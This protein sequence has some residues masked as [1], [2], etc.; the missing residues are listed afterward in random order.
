MRIRVALAA[1]IASLALVALSGCASLANDPEH[2]DSFAANYTIDA[3]GTAHV[4]ETIHYDFGSTPDRHGILRFLDSHFVQSATQDR[5]YKY[6]NLHVSSP[7]GASA[8][9]STAT[10]EDVLVQVGN[11]NATVSGKQTYI[12]SYDI[13]GALNQTTSTSGA[14]LDEL[15]W[16]ATG[17]DWQVPIDSA[18]VSV[19]GPAGSTAV[20]CF[21][22]AP[23]A[24]TS[25]QS[26]TKTA[27]G[28]T[29]TQGEFPAGD[30][31]TVDVGW[32]AG[33]FTSTAP[34]LEPHLSPDSANVYA[35]SNNGP[36]PFWTPWN[37]G[38]GLGLLVLIPLSYL[39]FVRLRDRDQEFTGE[40]PGTVPLDTPSAPVGPAPLH[41][42]LVVQYEPPKGF[43][44]G[45]VSLLM[46][47]QQSK[48]DVTVT[49]L[50]LAARGHLR[51][52]EVAGGS[53]SKASD[54][55][56]V[57]T[58]EKATVGDTAALLPHESLLL[59]DLFAGDTK[60][61]SLSNLKYT[62]FSEYTAVEVAIKAWVQGG[63]Y[64]IDKLTRTHPVLRW[65]VVASIATFAI[66][67]FFFDKS[68]TLWPIGAF[69]GAVLSLR[70]GRRAIRRSALGH[71][72]AVQLQGFKMYIAT[73]EA[74][75]IHFEE[76]IDVFS[77]YLPWATAFG[78][79][80]H[81]TG[82]FADLAKQGKYNSNLDWYVGD[83]HL[84]TNAGLAGSLAAVS[85][86][87]TAVSSF[88]HFASES[89][90]AS[91]H[92][93]GSSGGSGFG[94]D[95]GGGGGDMGGGGGG[96]GGGSW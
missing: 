18:S 7:T 33:T 40:T 26:Q 73:A 51:I 3:S 81:W 28:G 56:L 38:I 32:P 93:S 24:T 45:A 78:E 71:A 58:P 87:G 64:F 90:S 96:G 11:K 29:F 6:S 14:K 77:R 82:V 19:T 50:D 62:F 47:K 44:V 95:F 89:M 91:P 67:V 15:Y 69:I 57:A 74:D 22:G 76:G 39:V 9:F 80:D 63:N 46:D 61:V 31:V 48:L 34:I 88:S 17:A 27:N 41:E 23:G 92:T 85:S 12:L 20:A 21:A 43:P 55:N 8:L 42:T 59:H 60:T 37:W 30:G 68:W 72:I 25:C 79:A 2:I 1:G 75:Q 10:Q 35:G 65:I 4:V 66:M 84:L 53:K 94:G 70:A 36:D 5:V 49:L 16:N 86:L 52:E 54:Y 13:H 83:Q